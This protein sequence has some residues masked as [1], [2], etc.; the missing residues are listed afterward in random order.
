MPRRRLRRNRMKSGAFEGP[1]GRCPDCGEKT[2][3]RVAS[4]VSE[5][6]LTD[7]TLA[8]DLLREIYNSVVS[9]KR[10]DTKHRRHVDP[11][12]GLGE[13]VTS[14]YEVVC[15]K[16]C[17][18]EAKKLYWVEVGKKSLAGPWCKGCLQ[19]RVRHDLENDD[20]VMDDCR[21][22]VMDSNRSAVKQITEL[23]HDLGE[24]EEL[25]VHEAESSALF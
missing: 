7:W 9:S 22:F 20:G 4:L 11:N 19:T 3:I 16:Y 14:E 17:S 24:S 2:P 25:P 6:K 10:T 15:C 21:I 13:I 1:S 8:K 5:V 23:A 12:T 18:R